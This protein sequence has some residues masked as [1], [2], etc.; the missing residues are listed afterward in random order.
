MLKNDS[1]RGM[2]RHELK[3][4]LLLHAPLMLD[5]YAHYL[6]GK[7]KR[8]AQRRDIGFYEGLRILGIYTDTTAREALEGV[9]A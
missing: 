5:S 7:L 4:E 3:A 1:V 2:K 9:P 8:A 6:A